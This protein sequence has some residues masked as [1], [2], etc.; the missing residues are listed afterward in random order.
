MYLF[1]FA[2]TESVAMRRPS[3]AAAS[4]EYPL[5]AVCG[6]LIEAASLAAEHGLQGMWAQ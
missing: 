4:R 5:I 1:I 3:V 2:C 6:L